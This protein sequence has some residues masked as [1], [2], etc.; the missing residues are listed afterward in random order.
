MA[1][2]RGKIICYVVSIEHEGRKY[3]LE[4]EK[5]GTIDPKTHKT[6]SEPEGTFSPSLIDAMKWTD[7]WVAEMACSAYEGAQV[8]VI[9]TGEILK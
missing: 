9:K 5:M 3:Y 2:A 7:K 8:E 1:K 6:T 4:S